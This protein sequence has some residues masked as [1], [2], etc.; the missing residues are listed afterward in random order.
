MIKRRITF[1]IGD[2]GI[3]TS[4]LNQLKILANHFR[5]VVVMLNITH[6]RQA[7]IEQTVRMMSLGCKQGYLCQLLIEGSDAELACMVFI[8]FLSE[9][10]ILLNSSHKKKNRNVCCVDSSDE[11]NSTFYLP[12]EMNF[13][14]QE[15]VGN[16]YV[17]EGKSALLAQLCNMLNIKKSELLLDLMLRREEVSS[18]AMGNGIALPHVMSAEIKEPAMAM[19]Q[20][21]QPIEWKSNQGPV[22][23]LIAMVLPAPAQRPHIQ[24]FSHFSK[25]LLDP[26]FCHL[27]TDNT[28]SEALK[29]I[30]LHTLSRPFHTD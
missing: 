12:F 28:E 9:H 24:A 25:S 30:I 19:I 6:L 27:L 15:L 20:T 14:S 11:S 26:D 1:I 29:A 16:E 4:E 3:P 10:F 18:T 7:N 22:T 23:R 17:S 21:M 2:E 5:A 8:D 13:T